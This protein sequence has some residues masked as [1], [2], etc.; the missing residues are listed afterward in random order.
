MADAPA[1]ISE[2]MRDR[3]TAYKTDAPGAGEPFPDITLGMLDG[4][5][6]TVGSLQG[7]AVVIQTGAY[8]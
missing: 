2:R 6:R 1:S 5:E 7:K 3:M 4:S 8:T